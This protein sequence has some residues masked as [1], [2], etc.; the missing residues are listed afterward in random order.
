MSQDDKQRELL[1]EALTALEPFAREA[2][3]WGR[4]MNDE[5]VIYIGT[6]ATEP[7]QSRITVGDLRR[8]RAAAEALRKA[9]GEGQS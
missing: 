1:A 5:I 8:A 2:G 7:S 6:R 4:E 3:C 9:L